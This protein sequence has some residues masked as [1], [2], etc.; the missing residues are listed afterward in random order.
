MKS[1][2]KPAFTLIEILVATTVFVAAMSIVAAIMVS[3]TKAISRALATKKLSGY[4]RDVNERLSDEMRMTSSI[5]VSPDGKSVNLSQPGNVTKVLVLDTTNNNKKITLDGK[6]LLSSDTS[7][8]ISAE[9]GQSAFTN[10]DGTANRTLR[11]KLNF[12]TEKGDKAMD[13]ETMLTARN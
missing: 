5:T 11:L 7:V 8:K 13:Y 6:N 9:A 3:S 2:K 4:V 1:S 12:S 10:V